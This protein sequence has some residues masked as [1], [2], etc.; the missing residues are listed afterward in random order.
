MP[1]GR[2]PGKAVEGTRCLD[3]TGGG[4]KKEMEVWRLKGQGLAD[5]MDVMRADG[6]EIVMK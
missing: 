2:P 1:E 4:S 6:C 3:A 5:R